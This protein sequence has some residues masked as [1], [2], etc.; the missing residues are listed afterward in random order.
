LSGAGVR[1]AVMDTGIDVDHPDLG[2][3]FGP[4]C[5]VEVG[6]DFVGDA[7]N[8]DSA[9]PAYNPVAVPDNNPDDCG[10]HGTHV[11]GIVGAN[12]AVKGAAPGVTFGAYRVFG[13]A[14]STS[15]DIMIAAMERIAKDGADVLNMSI[16]S[17]YQWPQYPTAQAATRL[18][19]KKGI[20][21]VA[22]TGNNGANGLWASGAPGVGEKVI[23]VAS[24]DNTHQTL[25]A[26]TIT[27]D[28]KAIGY[29]Q[30]TASPIAPTSGTWPLARTGTQTTANDACNPLPAGS[31]TGKYV[32]IRRGTCGFNAKAINAQNAGAAGVI[33]YNNVAGIQNTTVVGPPTVTIPTVSVSKASG[34]LIDTRLAAG[35]VSLTWTTGLTGDPNLNTANVISGFS[36]YGLSP[37]LDIKPDIGAPGGLIWSTYPLEKGGYLTNNGTSMASPHVAGTVALLLEARPGL[38]PE[39]VRTLLQNTA[40][41]KAWWGNPA[42]GLLDNVHRQGAGM[43]QIADAVQTTSHVTPSKL[44]LGESEAGPATRTLTVTNNGATAVTY[45]LGHAPALATGPNTFTPAFFNGPS[46]VTFSSPTVTVAAGGIATFDVTI[47]PNG[48]LADRSLYGGYILLTPQGGGQQLSVPFAGIKGDYQSIQV[49]VPTVNNF[50]WLARQV[51]ANFVNQP[52][53]ATYTL[54][55]TDVPFLV[56]HFDHQVQR[57]EVE[58]RN[59]ATGQKLHP[60][61]SNAIEDEFLPRNSGAATFFSFAWDGTRL[62]NNGNDKVKVVPDGQYTLTVKALKALGD[63]NNPA[64]WETWTSPVV[65][66]DRP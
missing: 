26:F 14:G 48:G 56:L 6:Y 17:G 42:L 53:G 13:C 63:A 24:F 8:N 46:T 4:G 66:L 11:A 34:D 36:S 33:L 54:V 64:H 59:A 65:T 31:L 55:G 16:G 45:D 38:T 15:S 18:V 39:E 52:G 7:Y 25:K 10:G 19:E 43:V 27:A 37:V 23:A 9:S 3:C 62:H 20:V 51:G 22:S 32:L 58:I 49:L 30:A 47:S 61:F 41:P 29:I 2:G 40:E 5:R 57:L 28:N 35:P 60:V 21:V 44:A 1:V 50:P 12:G